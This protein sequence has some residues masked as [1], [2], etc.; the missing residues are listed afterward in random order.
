[1]HASGDTQK[2]GISHKT[3]NWLFK[4]PP[5]A[6][7]TLSSTKR[8]KKKEQKNKN[9][10]YEGLISQRIKF[11]IEFH[12]QKEL[13]KFLPYARTSRSGCDWMKGQCVAFKTAPYLANQHTRWYCWLI[14]VD[15]GFFWNTLVMVQVSEDLHKRATASYRNSFINW[16]LKGGRMVLPERIKPCGL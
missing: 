8:K 6:F 13:N 7:Q 3:A 10:L 12:C 14:H 15:W 2:F 16:A 1:M 11:S 9:I 5:T 4:C